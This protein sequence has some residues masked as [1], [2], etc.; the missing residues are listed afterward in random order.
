MGTGKEL[1]GVGVQAQ[2]VVGQRESLEVVDRQRLRLIGRGQVALH[3]APRLALER[4]TPNL[5]RAGRH[6]GRVGCR[7]GHRSSECGPAN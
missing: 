3:I 1:A 6:D 5:E 7:S 2:Q 4:L